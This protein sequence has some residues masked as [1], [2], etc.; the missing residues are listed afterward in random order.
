MSDNVFIVDDDAAIRKSLT[1]LLTGEGYKAHAYPDVRGFTNA[2]DGESSGVLLL[3]IAMPGEDGLVFLRRCR[4][5]YPF[6]GVIMITGEATIDR[7]VAATKLG[8]YDFLE[9]PLNPPRLL[10][11]I[12]NLIDH[13]LLTR[14]VAEKEQSEQ[15]RYR[16][17]GDSP[18]MQNLRATI[19]RVAAADSTV[20]ITGENGTGKELVA[21]N[22]WS[23]SRRKEG[24]YIKVNCAAIPSDL[25]EAEL[26]GYRRGAFTGADRN[27]DGKF[28][29]ADGGTIFLDE[30]GD[31]SGAVQAK[32]LRILETGELE[33]LGSDSSEHVDVRLLAATN[34][35]LRSLVSEGKF[36][37]DLYYRLNVVPIEI[38]ALRERRE[39][40]A[41]LV[42][43]FADNLAGSTGLGRK[44]LS[45]EAIGYLSGL[46]FRGNIRELRNIVERCYIMSRAKRIDLDELQTYLG[47]DYEL[48]G[49]DTDSSRNSLTSALRNFE[50]SFLAGELSKAG[51]NI[52][53]MARAL[54]IDRGN[55]SRKLKS[56]GLV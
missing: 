29:A 56:Y 41:T 55:L 54:G 45:A 17:I 43:H 51:G 46:E 19:E 27:R 11:S 44:T 47:G 1:T 35:E 21:W 5:D 25:S 49:A 48:S 4:Q 3:D 22:I 23:Q 38:P 36:R 16:L 33:P 32:L 2:T 28:K 42:E 10:L 31:L 8:A 40:I 14:K 39:D 12:K 52:S 30:I 7:A 9:K 20:L 26:F 6:L 37:E 18:A 15:Y 13:L 53:E 24:A 50:K 34:R